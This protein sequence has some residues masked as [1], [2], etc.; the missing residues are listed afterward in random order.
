MKVWRAYL[1]MLVLAVGNAAAAGAQNPLQFELLTF[2]CVDL[3][4]TGPLAMQF[5]R[6]TFRPFTDTGLFAVDGQQLLYIEQ[7]RLTV[8]GDRVGQEL[9]NDG[10]SYL[11]SPGDMIGVRNDDL[12]DASLLWLR[13]TEQ[14]NVGQATRFAAP[15]AFRAL[16]AIARADMQGPQPLFA[17]LELQSIPDGSGNLFIVRL[18]FPP[19]TVVSASD[20][21]LTTTGVAALVVDVGTLQL[22]NP[23]T[24]TLLSGDASLVETSEL[25]MQ[26]PHEEPAVAFLVGLVTP[27]DSGQV[28]TTI[29]REQSADQE[30]PST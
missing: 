15:G 26:N 5:E 28:G 3:R 10:F 16:W 20:A 6:E 13:V 22:G 29:D 12:D 21:P 1:L 7:G 11:A 30:C 4:A 19:Q 8:I 24:Q 17:Q 23:P 2:A 25:S 14:T 18:D 27:T 9:A